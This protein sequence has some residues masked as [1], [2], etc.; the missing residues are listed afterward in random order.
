[1]FRVK[2]KIVIKQLTQIEGQPP[3]NL[4][5]KFDF[6]NKFECSDSWRDFTNDGSVILPKNITAVSEDGLTKIPLDGLNTHIGGVVNPLLMRGD[7]ITMD[8]YYQYFNEKGNEV[9]EGTEGTDGSHLFEGYISEISSKK[10]IEFKV[11][12]NFFQLKQTP[13]PTKTFVG[14]TL[15][16]IIE[17]LLQPY[18]IA[19]PN[20]PF[21]VNAMQVTTFGDFRVGN[22][23]VSECLGRL[24]KQCG[25]ESYF[26]GDVL[27]SG[28][29]VY[30]EALAIKRGNKVF[31]FQYNIISDELR[32][33]RK[34]DL[35]LSILAST[36]TENETGE[37]T[38]TGAKKTK[39]E[40]IEVL[41]TLENGSDEPVIFRKKKGEDYP[42]NSG[43][44]RRNFPY[45]TAKTEKELID[46]A[47]K[48]IK[49][50]YYSGFKGK[51]TTF[52]LPFVRTGDNI[53][54]IDDILPERNGIYKC[55]SV[56]YTCGV[57]GI[58]QEI[59]LDYLIIRK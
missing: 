13:C 49:L 29:I 11:E 19:H 12:D 47:T 33:Q 41:L 57:D 16:G 2:S 42:P 17:E 40:R 8:Y 22:E 1:M 38:K 23:T 4:T 51:F 59:E 9:I 6:V 56:N 46:A 45:V 14:Y 44:E 18:N 54:L 5:L 55:K 25:F 39:K 27:Y 30:D 21:T 32:Y 26:R 52:G 35:K 20:K 34:E 48:E 24:R 3:R 28:L 50:Y 36:S 7:A 43:G 58:R 37:T 15:K 53:Q 10:P 31:K